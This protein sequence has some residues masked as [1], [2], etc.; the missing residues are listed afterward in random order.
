MEYSLL[1]GPGPWNVTL[2]AA[3]CLTFSVIFSDFLCDFL[4]GPYR[5]QK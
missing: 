5:H 2:S 4:C 1:C 3:F